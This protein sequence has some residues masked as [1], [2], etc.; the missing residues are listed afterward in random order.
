MASGGNKRKTTVYL[1]E[2]LLRAA[3]IQAAREGKKDYEVFEEA[4]RSYL[5]LGVVER[6]WERSPLDEQEA[7]DLAYRELRASRRARR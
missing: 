1:D 4:L 2:G 5:G 3:K 6:A 7:L